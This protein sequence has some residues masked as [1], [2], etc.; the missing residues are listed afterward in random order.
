MSEFT[1]SPASASKRKEKKINRIEYGDG[2][3]QRSL[4]GINWRRET[5]DLVFKGFSSELDAIE[6]FLD[7]QGAASFDWYPPN[8]GSSSPSKWT[9]GAITRTPEGPGAVSGSLAVTF[10]KE[11]DLS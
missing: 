2:Y 7:T 5:W 10:T 3:S 11:F 4:D 9:S 1:W 8:V 6:A